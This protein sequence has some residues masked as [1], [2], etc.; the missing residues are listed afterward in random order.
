MIKLK[1]KSNIPEWVEY[2]QGAAFNVCP[3]VLFDLN[4]I[5]QTEKQ[6]LNSLK[7]C[8]WITRHTDCDEDILRMIAAFVCIDGKLSICQVEAMINSTIGNKC[9]YNHFWRQ[10]TNNKWDE[11][12]DDDSFYDN[13]ESDETEQWEEVEINQQH[14]K[15]QYKLIWKW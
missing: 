5:F 12:I 11:E 13:L 10:I 4:G 14:S 6:I 2:R 9:G 1:N 15:W 7:Q 3:I 8:H